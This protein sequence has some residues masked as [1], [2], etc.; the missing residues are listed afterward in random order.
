MVSSGK[1]EMRIDR[2]ALV[3]RHHV[4]VSRVDD[5]TV[6]QVGNGEFAF[7]VDVTGLQT[8][9]GNTLSHWGWHSRPSPQGRRPEELRLE[10]FET[11]GRKVG[12]ATDQAGQEELFAW[13]RENPHR[14][15]LGRLRLLLDGHPITPAALRAVRQRLDLW[16]GLVTSQYLLDGQ[17]VCVETCCHPARDVVAAKV[18]SPLVASGRLSVEITFPYGDHG[19]SGADWNSPQAHTTSL[20]N[21]EENQAE[22]MRQLDDDSYVVGMAWSGR[23][24]L[25]EQKAHTFMLLPES[26]DGAFELVCAFSPCLDTRPPPVFSDVK[27][28]ASAHWREFWST[29]GAIDLSESKD[30]RWR[31]LERR[32]VLSQYLL[33]VNEAG[34]LPPQESGLY[35]NSGWYG[36]FHL[37]MHWWHGAHYALWNRWPLFA[38]SL[39]WY[40]GALEAA[41]CLARG[42]GY[43][44]A[45]WP[46][47]VGPDGR[48]APSSIG[49]LLIWQQPHPI[50]Y[51][52]LDY[53]LH[54]ERET[55]EK[56]QEVVFESADFMASYAVLDKETGHFVLGPP[57]KTVSENSD[58]RTTRN[59]VFELSYWRFGLRTAQQWRARLGLPPE[60]TWGNVLDGLATLPSAEGCYL[61]QE[62]MLDTYA[63]WNWEHPS[64]IGVR[65]MLPGDG[66]DPVIMKATVEK[67]MATWQWDRCW[68]WDFPMMAMA[69]ARNGNP[70]MAVEALLHP[71]EKN[72]FDNVGLS[73]GGPFPY[74]PSNGG[75]LYAVAMMAAGWDGCPDTHAPGFPADG[76]WVVKWEGLRKSI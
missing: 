65:G 76:S 4:D 17:P 14:I 50:F 5:S 11:D 6:M 41:R 9:W 72:G 15:N 1:R 18:E 27:T 67:V 32:I 25:R 48:D 55:L 26:N 63:K 34:S 71:S 3:T 70:P 8:M 31:E 39:G 47:M 57:L 37:E 7:G 59:P 60:A 33:A 53:R 19:V 2:H 36:K 23:A 13:L 28:A 20:R 29:G 56:W 68:G 44:G 54:P 43:R 16:S 62:G 74:F 51:A 73:M 30:P 69:A 40:R 45:R 42:Q 52:E 66:V 21:E 49:P 46:K 22:F 61:Q 75:L 35:N 24:K 58:T 10:E 12:Y 38:R 64:L